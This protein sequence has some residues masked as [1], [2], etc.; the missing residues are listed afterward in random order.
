MSK[1]NS[2]GS[3]SSR[4]SSSSSSS[5]CNGGKKTLSRL[6][7]FLYSGDKKHVVAGI[8]IVAAIGAIPWLLFTR[9][10]TLF[11]SLHP[12]ATSYVFSYVFLVV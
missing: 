1:S 7:Q 3:S 12:N 8:L 5:N 9:G 2:D 11:F 6:D 4:S 10:T